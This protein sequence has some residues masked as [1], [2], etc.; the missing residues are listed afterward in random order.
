MRRFSAALIALALTMACTSPPADVSR[1]ASTE[2]GPASTIDQVLG[3]AQS[4]G[5]PAAAHAMSSLPAPALNALSACQ[6]AGLA[7]DLLNLKCPR[8]CCS[9][10]DRLSSNYHLNPDQEAAVSR[11]RAEALRMA[12]STVPQL[13]SSSPS[14]VTDRDAMLRFFDSQ[15][16]ASALQPPKQANSS[17]DGG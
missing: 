7:T 2:D 6:M 5:D 11:L 4:D 9:C 10:L 15:V 8:A 1:D 17:D 13:S 16:D 3:I 14:D 12:R